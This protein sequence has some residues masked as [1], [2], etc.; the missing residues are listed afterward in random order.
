MFR[1][2]LVANRGEIALR[3]VR[4]AR[5]LG[6]ATVVVY[7]DIDRDSLAVQ[8]ADEACCVGARAA[9]KSY[10]NIPNIISAA[11]ITGADAIHPGYGF[12]AESAFFAEVCA[13]HGIKFIGPSPEAISRLGDK[14]EAK[15]TMMKAGLPVIPGTDGVI[16]DIEEA[17][18]FARDVGYPVIVK[19]AGGGGGKGM[20][21]ARNETELKKAAK[22]AEA[23]AR[24][25]FGTAALYVE[26][27]I[28]H[29]RHVEVQVVADEKGN[30]IYLGERDCSLQRKHQKIT[31][32]A[33]SPVVS[34]QLRE[35]MGRAAVKGAMAAGYTNVGTMEFLLDRA[36]NF[37]FMEMNTRIQVEHPV[38]EMITGVD[39][40]KEQILIA[41]GEPL[42][43]KQE[44]V[45]LRGHAI[46]CRICA[47]DPYRGFMPSPGT[48]RELNLPGGPG[49]RIDT[50]LYR[51]LTV[52]PDYDSLIAKLIAWGR[53]RNEAISR[54]QRALDELIIEGIATNIDLQR[55]IVRSEKFRSATIYADDDVVEL[56]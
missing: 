17:L 41:A 7:S 40:V 43:L 11:L 39:L 26:K 28:E 18:G 52:P 20:R 14:A 36:G 42:S 35:K 32:E 30:C 50:A 13:A 9:S 12:L 29:P 5:E 38:T 56:V 21:V 49:I 31:E 33:P 48:I 45:Y 54:M 37:Y 25:A 53:D 34:S 16:S 55:E 27:F 3:I 47:E 44:D 51:G 1:K 22:F 8:L 10:L 15:R 4:A 19:A 6:I 46:E 24:A 2:I 23:E